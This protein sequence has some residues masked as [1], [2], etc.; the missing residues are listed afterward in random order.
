MDPLGY[1]FGD[2]DS[3]GNLRSIDHGEP[4]DVSGS[5]RLDGKQMTYPDLKDFSRQMAASC[6]AKE[7][8]VAAFLQTALAIR[9]VPVDERQALIERDE[10]TTF[11]GYS[12][13]Q[14]SYVDLVTAFAQSPVT[15]QP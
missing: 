12:V 4:I 6:K 9:G 15:L 8:F 14:G 11:Q 2:F 5:Y 1:P 7:S 3:M 13:T 10:E